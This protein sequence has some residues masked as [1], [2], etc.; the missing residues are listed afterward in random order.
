MW[1]PPWAVGIGIR[2]GA[3][4]GTRSTPYRTSRPGNAVAR[5]RAGACGAGGADRVRPMGGLFTVRLLDSA[6]L[7]T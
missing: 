5:Q 6:K 4:A 2:D 1:G 3:C 7:G